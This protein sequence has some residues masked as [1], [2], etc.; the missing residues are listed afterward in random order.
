MSVAQRGPRRRWTSRILPTYTAIV[1][2]Y[3]MLPIFVMILFGFNDTTG[4][5]NF[6]W[7]GFTLRHYRELFAIQDLTT[8]LRNSLSIAALS[9]VFATILGTM[10]ALAMGRYRF[11]GK[12][13]VNMMMFMNIA[14]PEVVLGAS[15]LALFVTVN[16][17]R[18]FLTILIAHVM[19]N[20]AY[21][22]ITVEA[23]LAGFDN[24]LEEAAQDLGA[25]PWTA[26]W[27]VIFPLIFPGVLAG[28]LLAFALSIDDYVITSFVA[29]QTTTFPLWVFGASRLGIPPQV[30]V[31]GTLIFVGGAALA[32]GN[33]LWQR[34]MARAEVTAR[35]AV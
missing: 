32:V 22:A 12:S 35:T 6:T 24:S 31:M 23:R 30:N 13:S 28:A 27:K 9:T 17:S 16:V 25:R 2:L 1:I 26:F 19:F 11:R 14:S 4:R 15:L 21:V 8:A 18:G 3:L 10:I 7:Q 33:L 5:F 34:R 20:I 29:G